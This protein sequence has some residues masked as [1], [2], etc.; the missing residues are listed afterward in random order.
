M[1]NRPPGIAFITLGCAKNEVDSD[2]MRARV[3]RAGFE[4]VADAAAADAVIV[5]TCSFITEATEEAISTI[6]EVLDLPRVAAGEAR[7][8]V[9]G[10]L[11]ARYGASL[12]EELPEVSAFV[13]CADEDQIAEVLTELLVGQGNGVGPGGCPTPSPG[14][15][16]RTVSAPWAYV[17][18]AD[19][20]D[21][22]CSFCTIPRIR[23][24]YHSVPADEIVAEVAELVDGGVREIV[25]IAQDTGI[26][27]HDGC[28]GDVGPRTPAGG[29]WG[30]PPP[31]PTAGSK[32]T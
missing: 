3:L 30:E 32:Q 4:V 21:R 18:I 13:T 15:T 6:L 23:G 17:K 16:Q 5:N 2:K 11:P 14:P 1:L 12:A 19:G 29:G 24:H 26:W 9:T 31:N 27:G 7:L 28:Q 22:R 8:V 25:L 20:C 10:C